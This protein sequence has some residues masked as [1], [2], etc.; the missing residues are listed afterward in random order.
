MGG[1][2]IGQTSLVYLLKWKS[3]LGLAFFNDL[4]RDPFF[5]GQDP[6]QFNPTIN[7]P[8]SRCLTYASM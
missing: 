5:K 3:E 2:F 7:Q 4:Q 8:R 6:L 1:H